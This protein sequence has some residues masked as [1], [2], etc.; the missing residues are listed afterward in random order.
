MIAAAS[1]FPAGP[2]AVIVRFR[3][4]GTGELQ[5]MDWLSADGAWTADPDA[6]LVHPDYLAADKLAHSL[7]TPDAW[8]CATVRPDADSPK[9]RALS[10]FSEAAEVR[11]PSG[12]WRDR[13][14]C[15]L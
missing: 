2:K 7:R 14:D 8:V 5:T 15:G 12:D 10:F 1:L 9:S 3:E 6:A 13:K 11:H 4:P